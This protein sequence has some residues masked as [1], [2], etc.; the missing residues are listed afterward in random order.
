MG[1]MI[2][3]CEIFTKIALELPQNSKTPLFKCKKLVINT[4]KCDLL[5]FFIKCVVRWSKNFVRFENLMGTD[6][7]KAHIL[8]EFIS[9]YE[10]WDVFNIGILWWISHHI[11]YLNTYSRE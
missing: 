9:Q 11:Q 1:D 8:L 5:Y 3:F 6:F 10:I 7:Q 2:K 4:I